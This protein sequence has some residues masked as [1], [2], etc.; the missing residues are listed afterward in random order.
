MHSLPV[1]FMKLCVWADC[2]SDAVMNLYGVRR[3]VKGNVGNKGFQNCVF[4][5]FR[6]LLLPEQREEAGQGDPDISGGFGLF[7]GWNIHPCLQLPDPLVD[8]PF[9]FPVFLQTVAAGFVGF[10]D[11]FQPPGFL[12][13]ASGEGAVF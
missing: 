9:V 10:F 4:R 13:Q 6:Y 3:A 5:R 8:P 11:P 12:L 7:R 2:R 1:F